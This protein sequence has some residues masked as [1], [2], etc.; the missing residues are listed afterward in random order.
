MNFTAWDVGG[1]DKMVSEIISSSVILQSLMLTYH[2]I[3]F[4]A[5]DVSGI[6]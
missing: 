4:T 2:G 1:R 3:N 5:W 6:V